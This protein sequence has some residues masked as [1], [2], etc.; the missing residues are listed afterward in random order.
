MEKQFE[1]INDLI[2]YIYTAEPYP[3]L[4]HIIREMRPLIPYSHSLSN[5]ISNSE[6]GVEFFAYQSDDIPSEHIDLYKTKYM[7]YDF[8]L[9]YCAMPKELVLRETDLITERYMAECIFTKEWLEPINVYYGLTSNIARENNS[10]GN[11]T[12]YRSK[13]EG[14]FTDEEIEM[15]EK[16]IQ[17]LSIRFHQ[18]F[19]NGIIRDNADEKLEFF[20]QQYQLTKR[21]KEI[22]LCISNHIYRKDLAKELVLSEHTVKKH[23]NS[24]YRKTNVRNFSEL[25]SL[26]NPG[27]TYFVG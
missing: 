3:D 22:V 19:P 9:W 14:N 16:I 27:K 4:S 7:Y 10:Y 20:V 12:F 21:E 25:Y 23:L 18:L 5:L 11:I 8:V 2:L 24:I 13:E 26:I 6:K 17:H 15:L 1:K